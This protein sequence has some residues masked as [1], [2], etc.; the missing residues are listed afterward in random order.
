MCCHFCCSFLSPEEFTSCLVGKRGL[1]CISAFLCR[2]QF[3][4]S[5]FGS[6]RCFLFSF[7][8]LQLFEPRRVYQLRGVIPRRHGAHGVSPHISR[9]GGWWW[10]GKMGRGGGRKGEPSPKGKRGLNRKGFLSSIFFLFRSS[11]S[12]S[13]LSVPPHNPCA[14]ARPDG[15]DEA[16]TASDFQEEAG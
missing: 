5:L 1:V 11:S 16:P 14:I 4:Y 2:S 6:K 12:S 8:L 15:C 3:L 7:F 9:E 13:L 10:G